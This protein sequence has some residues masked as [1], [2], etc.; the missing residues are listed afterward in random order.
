MWGQP[1]RLPIIIRMPKMIMIYLGQGQAQPEQFWKLFL[2][3][4]C[5]IEK[6]QCVGQPSRLPIL[7][8]VMKFAT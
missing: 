4:A 8:R 3:N 6:R 2:Q 1:S 7:M 5:I